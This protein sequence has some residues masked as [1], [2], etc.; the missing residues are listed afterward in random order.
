VIKK[1]QKNK[2]VCKKE[3]KSNKKE[4]NRRTLQRTKP[5][6]GISS[7]DQKNVE[8]KKKGEEGVGLKGGGM[9]CGMGSWGFHSDVTQVV[10][11]WFEK[12]NWE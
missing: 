1:R 3:P 12:G 2:Q 4:R 9:V 7:R 6:P 10:E 8:K 11:W 5:R